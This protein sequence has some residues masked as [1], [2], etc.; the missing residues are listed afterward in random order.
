MKKPLYIL[1]AVSIL[2]ALAVTAMAGTRLTK[3][4]SKLQ[5]PIQNLKGATAIP[6]AA[7]CDTV[8]STSAV[9]KNYST[10]GYLG[11]KANAYN[12]NTGAP[13]VVKWSEDGKHVWTGSEYEAVNPSGTGVSTL[14]AAA[15]SGH[16]TAFCIR[17]H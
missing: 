4:S 3:D 17:R 15:F 12:H 7:R 9:Q 11:L 14:N 1:F 5:T 16:T 10:A 13:I 6:A 8:A 2:L